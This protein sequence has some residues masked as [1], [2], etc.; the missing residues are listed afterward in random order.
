MKLVNIE[1]NEN[2]SHVLERVPSSGKTEIPYKMAA[3][4][5]RHFIL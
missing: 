3:G 1:Q 4:V 5:I 2:H